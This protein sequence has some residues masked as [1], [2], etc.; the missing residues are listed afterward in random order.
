MATCFASCT[1]RKTSHQLQTIEVFILGQNAKSKEQE[2]KHIN[3]LP[4]QFH[5]VNAI[6]AFSLAIDTINSIST[7]NSFTV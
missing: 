3:I 5:S 1:G 4:T 7:K 6:H 2:I